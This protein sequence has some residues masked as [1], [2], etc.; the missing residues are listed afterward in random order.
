VFPEWVSLNLNTRYS[1]NHSN[2]EIDAAELRTF[3][4]TYDE[5]SLDVVRITEHEFSAET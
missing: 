4:C 5:V 2:T 3:L 1:I